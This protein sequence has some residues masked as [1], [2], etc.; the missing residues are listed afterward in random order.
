MNFCAESAPRTSQSLRAMFF[1]APAACWWARMAVLSIMTSS[2]SGSWLSAWN[3]RSQTPVLVQRA[4]RV[5]VVCQLP[6]SGGRSR[7]GAPVRPIHSTASTN[8]R[9]SRAVTPRSPALPGS[10]A[11]I[12]AHWSSRS[13]HLS[14]S[15]TPAMSWDKSLNPI[16]NRL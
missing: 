7:Q 12:R 15:P 4:N 6:N 1:W 11:W 2:R 8:R 13:T 16:V 3:T 9:L 5:N 10:K 14:I